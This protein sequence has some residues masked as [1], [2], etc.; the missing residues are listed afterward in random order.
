M[1]NFY[2]VGDDFRFVSIHYDNYGEAH[3]HGEKEDWRAFRIMGPCNEHA[4]SN[5]I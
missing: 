2:H 1:R 3:G 5:S 4:Y